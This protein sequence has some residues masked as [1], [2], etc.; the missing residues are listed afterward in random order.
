MCAALF[1][2]PLLSCHGV[3]LELVNLTGTNVICIQTNGGTKSWWLASGQ[4][5]FVDGSYGYFEL[6]HSWLAGASISTTTITNGCGRVVMFRFGSGINPLGVIRQ[7]EQ[8]KMLS[9]S[10]AWF[11]GGFGVGLA[12]LTFGWGFR[13]VRGATG[14]ADPEP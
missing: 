7:W 5:A 1:A 2:A 12:M 11:S 4:S 8:E 9:D 3:E 6:R 13:I 10:L 14:A